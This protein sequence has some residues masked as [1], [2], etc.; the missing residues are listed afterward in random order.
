MLVKKK[1]SCTAQVS[2][3][4]RTIYGSV[5]DS[6]LFCLFKLNEE[7]SLLSN[8][9]TLAWDGSLWNRIEMVL[10]Q[11]KDNLFLRLGIRQVKLVTDQVHYCMRV[12]DKKPSEGG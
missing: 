6:C 12:F 11:V 3:C 4:Q 8:T 9:H 10:P 7:C 1:A 2:T 5:Y